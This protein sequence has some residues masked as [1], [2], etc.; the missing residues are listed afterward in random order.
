MPKMTKFIPYIF[1]LLLMLP[2]QAPAQIL[3]IPVEDLLMTI[4]DFNNAP[5]YNFWNGM[6]GQQPPMGNSSRQP[7]LN[8]EEELLNLAWDIFPQAE[9]IK[10]WNKKLIIKL[11]D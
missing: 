9:T 8:N 2:K 4:P 1:A 6:N 3:V 10:I 5:N 7:R 11:K